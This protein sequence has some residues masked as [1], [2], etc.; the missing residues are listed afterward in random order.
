MKIKC[1]ICEAEFDFISTNHLKVHGMTSKQYREK[2]PDA[3][4]V[5][6]EYSEMRRNSASKQ[7]KQQWGDYYKMYNKLH[8]KETVKKRI[9]TRSKRHWDKHPPNPLGQLAE[10]LVEESNS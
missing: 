6:E 7:F 5:S 3:V 9:A 2:Y 8:S 1:L 10:K 4:L